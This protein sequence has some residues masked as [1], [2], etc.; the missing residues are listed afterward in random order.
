MNRIARFS[1]WFFFLFLGNSV[2]SVGCTNSFCVYCSEFCKLSVVC[3]SLCVPNDGEIL[4]LNLYSQFWIEFNSTRWLVRVD[5]FLIVGGFRL[6]SLDKG[7]ETLFYSR[8]MIRC[9]QFF[10]WVSFCFGKQVFLLL[11]SFAFGWDSS[12]LGLWSLSRISTIVV[13]YGVKSFSL[14]FGAFCFAIRL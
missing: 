9:H 1:E 3:G 13:A 12:P 4:I 2:S 5:D 11:R 14:L 8:L 10:C 6:Y 7:V